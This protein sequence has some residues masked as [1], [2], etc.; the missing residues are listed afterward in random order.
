MRGYK[1]NKRDW[2]VPRAAVE[3]YEQRQ[4]SEGAPD[5]ED[6]DITEWRKEV[7]S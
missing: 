6:V 2:R 1:L 3:E 5:A 4:Q 7:S